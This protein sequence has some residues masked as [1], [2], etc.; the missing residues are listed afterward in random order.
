MSPRRRWPGL[1]PTPTPYPSFQAHTRR[2]AAMPTR[3]VFARNALAILRALAMAPPA[4]VVASAA[5]EANEPQAGKPVPLGEEWDFPDGMRYR[6]VRDEEGES[7]LEVV[8]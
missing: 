6:L 2:L 4:A 7:A 8:P 3:R 5:A 1:S